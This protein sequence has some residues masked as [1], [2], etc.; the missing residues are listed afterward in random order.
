MHAPDPAADTHESHDRP[1]AG[2]VAVR[3][4]RA[5][6]DSP[7]T[8]AHRVGEL[9]TVVLGESFVKVGL[10]DDSDGLNRFRIAALVLIITT[11]WV[12]YFGVVAR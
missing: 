5:G 9:T 1:T 11:L 8:Y 4:V 2:L 7:H 6:R 3:F 10:A 12:G